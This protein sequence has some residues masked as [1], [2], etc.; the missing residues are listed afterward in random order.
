MI[1]L[2]L[3]GP[4]PVETS[5]LKLEECARPEP[6]MGEVLLRVAACGICHTDLHVV[7]GELPPHKRPVVPGHQIVGR[8]EAVGSEVTRFKVGDRAGVPWL[9]WTCGECGFCSS[10]RE[11]LCL[12]ATFT[13]YDADG[14]YAEYAVVHQDF[15]LFLPDGLP[16][17]EAA[18]LL[19][20]G[21]IGYRALRLA[22]LAPGLAL[23][24]YGFGASAH[25]AL[26]VAVHAGAQVYVFS[27]SEGHRRLAESL[28]AVWVGSADSSPSEKLGASIIFAP[29]GELVPI[30]LDALDRGGRLVLAGIYMTAVPTMEYRRLYHERSIQ[31]VANATRR[32]GEEFLKIAAEG[33]VRVVTEAFPLKDGNRAL[34]LLKEGRIR[35]AGVLVPE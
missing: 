12:G 8:V 9:H 13:G 10:G 31:T 18:P 24:M 14:G 6:G 34:T 11:N 16:D 2:R 4:A 32:D 1:A 3:H 29:A 19:C 7:E 33:Q 23:G 20:A 35:G 17:A 27:R 22:G 5:P 21:I 25:L 15:A 28:G 30:A 26:Q